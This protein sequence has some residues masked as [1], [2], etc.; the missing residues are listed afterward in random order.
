MK[1]QL[2]QIE[3]FDTWLSQTEHCISKD[4]EIMA[5]NISG[6]DHQYQ[7]LAQVQDELVSQQQI[8]ESLQN[9]IIVIDDSSSSNDQ[10]SSMKYTSVEI[11]NKLLNLSERWAQICNFVQNR[12][13]QLQE[14]KIE[15]EQ[16]ESNQ[17]KV[18]KWLISK[19]N[20]M[21]QMKLETNINDTDILMKQVHSIQ[22]RN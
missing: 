7:E 10:D 18:D 9:M 5:K 13:I 14:V 19:E 17:D 11:E 6:I 3:S 1:L 15:F 4:L 12:W 2:D 8:T 21:N 20:E 22:V 16:I